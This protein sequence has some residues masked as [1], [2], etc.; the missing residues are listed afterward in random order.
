[1][2][3][4]N[5]IGNVRGF[6]SSCLSQF[7]L[8]KKIK[9]KPSMGAEYN[10]PLRK[11]RQENYH[12]LAQ[13]VTACETP[14]LKQTKAH[15]CTKHKLLLITIINSDKQYKI[16]C[17]VYQATPLFSTTVT[18]LCQDDSPLN[19]S[20]SLKLCIFQTATASDLPAADHQKTEATWFL[21]HP[22]HRVQIFQLLN[23]WG[24]PIFFFSGP[25]GPQVGHLVLFFPFQYM[26]FL[27]SL[28]WSAAK[29]KS[30]HHSCCSFVDTNTHP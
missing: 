28:A 29:E 11:L 4:N 10:V 13:R 30:T 6:L 24:K 15:T 8:A 19:T 1:M 14:H 17:A 9:Q 25:R 12:S 23:V 3:E 2:Q 27:C 21:C 7:Q 20:V 5:L 26:V 16:E 22:S 18:W